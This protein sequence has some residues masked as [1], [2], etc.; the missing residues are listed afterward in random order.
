[1]EQ[2]HGK[3]R[4]KLEAL[5]FASP[6]PLGAE[7]LASILE[8]EGASAADVRECIEQL[9]KEYE[10][11][12]HAFDIVEV[13]RG[14]RLLTRGELSDVIS[15]LNPPR[16]DKGLSE[17]AMETLAV[18][19]YRQPV[20]E[21][22][23]DAVRGVNCEG[24]LRTLLSKGLVVSAGRSED[25]GRPMLYKTS[26]E[27]LKYFNLASLDDLPSDKDFPATARKAEK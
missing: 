20:T 22:Q 7:R 10:S 17:A 2:E 12:G 18:I 9:R 1:M 4:Y 3:I 27:F 14:Y 11:H 23:V 21:A 25:P 19:A 13:A 5:L 26:D 24:A 6:E 16:R 15:R 8:P